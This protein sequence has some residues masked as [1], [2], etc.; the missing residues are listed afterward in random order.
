M[1]QVRNQ[2]ESRW[3][4]EPDFLLALFFGPEEGDDMFLRNID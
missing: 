3:Q 2:G 4:A 1:R